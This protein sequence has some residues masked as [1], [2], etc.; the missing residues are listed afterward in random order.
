[1]L[2]YGTRERYMYALKILTTSFLAGA[3]L[4][5]HT[6][7]RDFPCHLNILIL[8]K[9]TFGSE[10]IIETIFKMNIGNTAHLLLQLGILVPTK[11]YK[12]GSSSINMNN[13]PNIFPTLQSMD[14]VV[15]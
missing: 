4:A 8:Q 15:T 7:L 3:S 14:L 10:N 2:V 12:Y 13:Y 11:C 9:V 1:M 5:F 6:Q